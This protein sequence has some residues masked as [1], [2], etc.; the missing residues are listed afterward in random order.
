MNYYMI[1]TNKK[2]YIIDL[3]NNFD[4]AGFPDRQKSQ[5][6]KMKPGDKIVYYI[7]HDSKFC[8]I[9]EVI[10]EYFYS[11][12]QIWDDDFDVYPCRIA[13]K[14]LI[15]KKAAAVG[16]GYRCIAEGVYIKNIWDNLS[17][18]TNKGKWGSQV[19]GSFRRITEED[20]N[21]IKKA[22]EEL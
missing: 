20:Y 3:K 12:K 11:T 17:F 2:D 8:A 10:G 4:V 21:V 1:I 7:I 15:F 5:V 14:P 9:T 19:M 6:Q 13:T 18:I 16:N 22:L